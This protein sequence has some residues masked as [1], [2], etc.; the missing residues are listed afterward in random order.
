M[1]VR[2]K[3]G[4][5]EPPRKVSCQTVD[6]VHVQTAH[7]F[8][9]SAMSCFFVYACGDLVRLFKNNSAM[10]LKNNS[11]MWELSDFYYPKPQP[12][13]RFGYAF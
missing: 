4:R 11:A 7:F 12:R 10:L 3:P 6:F 2:T 13:P 1:V 9:N 8:C 5:D